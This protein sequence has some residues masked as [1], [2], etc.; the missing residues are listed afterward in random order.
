MKKDG[1]WKIWREG[2]MGRERDEERREMEEIW[3]EG[4]M[5]RERKEDRRGNG[6]DTERERGKTGRDMEEIW[7]GRYGEGGKRRGWEMEEIWR[8][9]DM[10]RE[11]KTGREMEEIWRGREGRQDGIWKRYGAG[12]MEREREEDGEENVIIK[13]HAP[14]YCKNQSSEITVKL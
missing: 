14:L 10:G 13:Y 12:D 6:R 1:R 7:S 5:G 8:E 4:D 11:R 2:D 3:R 9:G